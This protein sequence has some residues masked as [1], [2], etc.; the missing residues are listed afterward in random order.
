MITQFHLSTK[1]IFGPDS[2]KC[3]GTE[4]RRLGRKA[5]IVT[6]RKS[7]RRTGLL[8]RV[9]HDLQA[10]GVAALVYDK[11]E[12]NPRVSTVD[13]GAMLARKERVDMIIGLGGGSAMDAAKGIA[14]ASSN[15]RSIW[16]Y[17][18]GEAEVKGDVPPIIQVPTVAASG[19]EANQWAV[20]TNWDIHEKRTLLGQQNYAAVSIID[21]KLTL[22][23]PEKA[24][25]QGG[26]DLFAHL[27]EP[28]LTATEPTPVT[29][30][31][32]EAEMRLVVKYLPRVLDNL[33]DLEGR[34]VLS[35]VSPLCCSQF[36]DIGGGLGVTPAHS[37]EHAVSAFYDIAHGDG[38]AAILIGWMKYIQPKKEQRF[39]S[40]GLNVFGETDAVKAL[41]KWLEKINM[42]LRLRDFGFN[43]E[44]A[45][46]MGE[47]SRRTSL[48]FS[49]QKG[50]SSDYEW[51]VNH[52]DYLRPDE[53][54][55][56]YKLS[57]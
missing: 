25:A 43:L 23:L 37:L 32:L 33:Q 54:V 29:D 47:N 28:Y 45:V 39:V 49:P 20:I 27:V 34:T 51:Y 30:A 56:V 53:A 38:L 46:K 17:I 36:L 26:V 2:I 55:K 14:V 6:G 15:S 7:S 11:V 24:T 4:S 22:T 3:L 12:P 16:D 48:A 57:Y 35:W 1:L 13:E 10:N 41:E 44:Q 42:R 18:I 40:L 5:M 8:D 31:F 21:P 52:P 50:V 9:T 19:S